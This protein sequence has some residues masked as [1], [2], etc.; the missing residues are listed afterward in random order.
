MNKS[1]AILQAASQTF[2][3][4][5]YKATTMDQVARTANVG[6][7]TIYN[8]YATKE[9]LF[10]AVVMELISSM[11][12]T[13]EKEMKPQISFEKNALNAL[14]RLLQFRETHALYVKLVAEEKELRTPAVQSMLTKIEQEIT[15]ILAEKIQLAMNKGEIIQC[16]PELVSYLLLKSYIAMI[17]DWQ[18]THLNKLA[19][20]TISQLF[21]STIFK[22]LM[23]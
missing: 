2:S 20:D 10:Q 8:F 13:V 12:K 5:G 23:P 1:Q 18:D 21:Q 11:R 4:F 16:D 7:G 15:R 14:N 19:E 9:I 3:L 17:V 6:K 22:G